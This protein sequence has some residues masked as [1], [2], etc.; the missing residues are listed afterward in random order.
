M[1]PQEVSLI[2]ATLPGNIRRLMP[3]DTVE[4]YLAKQYSRDWAAV[5]QSWFFN[6]LDIERLSAKPGIDKLKAVRHLET[7]ID[8]F[9]PKYEYKVAAVAILLEEWFTDMKSDG[10]EGA[11]K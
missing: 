9:E 6:R 5:A 4:R 3:P 2:D 7:I 8:S 10:K 1:E 11:P